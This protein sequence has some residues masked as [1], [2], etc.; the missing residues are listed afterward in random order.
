M[1][2]EK[3]LGREFCQC[4]ICG[5]FFPY[6]LMCA[7]GVHKINK[8]NSSMGALWGTVSSVA[9][10]DEWVRNLYEEVEKKRNKTIP[11]DGLE[12]KDHYMDE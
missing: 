7:K 8:T 1:K 10:R 5:Q 11:D 6:L 2:Y 12:G 4:C 9:I 3:K